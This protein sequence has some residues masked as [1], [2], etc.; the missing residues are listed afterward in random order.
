M[1]SGE[2][3]AENEIEAKF[4]EE[5]LLLVL[6]ALSKIS[7]MNVHPYVGVYAAF[8]F[9]LTHC[10][11]LGVGRIP[12]ESVVLMLEDEN[13]TISSM[14]RANGRKVFLSC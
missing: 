6:S 8:R 4:A 3:S 5:S 1:S 12:E 9:E 14:R 2:S 11:T 10:F 13:Q 7:F